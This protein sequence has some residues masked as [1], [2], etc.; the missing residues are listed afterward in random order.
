MKLKTN[1]DCSGYG[2]VEFK[3]LKAV[4]RVHRKLADLD[5]RRA[6]FGLIKGVLVAGGIK[7]C[8]ERGGQEI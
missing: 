3:I 7:P 8:K 5:F 4:R 2:M 6:D 1:L